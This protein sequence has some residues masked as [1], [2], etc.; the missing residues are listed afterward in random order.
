MAKHTDLDSLCN[1]DASRREKSTESEYD[2]QEYSSLETLNYFKISEMEDYIHLKFAELDMKKETKK[3]HVFQRL[4]HFNNENIIANKVTKGP[5]EESF[6]SVAKYAD[7]FK[8]KYYFG[9]TSNPENRFLSHMKKFDTSFSMNILYY[10]SRMEKAAQMEHLLI[11]KYSRNLGS[12]NKNMFSSGLV[13]GKP[14]YYVY[15]LQQSQK[16]AKVFIKK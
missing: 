11:N 1:P 2:L 12:K 13:Y 16:L 4:L 8:Y 5:V 15:L 3:N 6:K 7:T 14:V 10:T 9:A